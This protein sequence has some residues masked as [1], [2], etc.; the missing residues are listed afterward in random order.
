MKIECRRCGASVK[1]GQVRRN[2]INISL[3]YPE[4]KL[5]VSAGAVLCNDCL[6]SA[7]KKFSELVDFVC[8]SQPTERQP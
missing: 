8:P 3:E 5:T 2:L 1:A 6:E 7:S 4:M